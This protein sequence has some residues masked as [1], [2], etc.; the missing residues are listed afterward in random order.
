MDFSSNTGPLCTAEELLR[1]LEQLPVEQVAITHSHEDHIGGLAPI[2]KRYPDVP[3]F[4]SRQA[5]PL[6]EDPSLLKLQAY[7]RWI[8]GAPSP[9]KGVRSLD[10]VDDMLR[11]QG[12]N[13]SSRRNAR[14][15]AA[16]M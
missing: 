9:V 11:T 13:F 6:I 5:I 7:R 16:I 2:C 14:S 8:W 15:S 1:V 10:D 4:A 3:V 12:I